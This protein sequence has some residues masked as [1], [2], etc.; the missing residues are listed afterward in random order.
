[1]KN[2]AA[3][4]PR[5]AVPKAADD[6]RMAN[7]VESNC[8]VLKIFDQCSFQIGIQVVLKKDVKGLDNDLTVRRLR[9][10]EHVAGKVNF[11]VTAASK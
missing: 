3:K 6:I 11:R 9:R 7:P 5:R 10:C 4:V 8:F 2:R 1:M